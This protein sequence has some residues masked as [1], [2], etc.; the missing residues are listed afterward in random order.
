MT[1][2]FAVD[3]NELLEHDLVMLS[4]TH[5]RQCLHGTLVQ[6][7]EG[8][9]I[10]VQE[11]NHYADGH[12]ELLFARGVVQANRTGTWLHV[13]WCCRLDAAG[14]CSRDTPPGKD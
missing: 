10:E 14:I 6:L 3:F 4:Q 8:L 12:H 5:E 11:E 7:T 2:C 9:V 13:K 1:P